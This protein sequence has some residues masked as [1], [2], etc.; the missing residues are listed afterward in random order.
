[1]LA[2]F[3]FLLSCYSH[4]ISVFVNMVPSF[5]VWSAF[6]WGRLPLPF[7]FSTVFQQKKIVFRLN[8]FFYTF[9]TIAVFFFFFMLFYDTST[10]H[11]ILGILVISKIFLLFSRN[12]LKKCCAYLCTKRVQKETNFLQTWIYCFTCKFSNTTRF[13]KSDF[14]S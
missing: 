11:Y 12:Q 1:M 5:Y 13:K 2:I 6:S 3:Q 9:F 7:F 10:S 8:T 4:N 14:I